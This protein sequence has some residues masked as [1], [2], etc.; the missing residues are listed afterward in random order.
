[1]VRDKYKDGELVMTADQHAQSL[2]DKRKRAGKQ[3]KPKAVKRYEKRI[4]K[5]I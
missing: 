3:G 2:V 4:G 1:M 5:I